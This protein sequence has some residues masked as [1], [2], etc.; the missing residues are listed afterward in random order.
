[1][2]VIRC[3]DI[4]SSLELLERRVRLNLSDNVEPIT[5]QLKRHET[6][7]ALY[8]GPIWGSTANSHTHSA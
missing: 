4:F 2:N 6:V 8:V 5:A 7:K 1:M 3:D